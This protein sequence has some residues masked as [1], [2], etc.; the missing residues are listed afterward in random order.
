MIL[1]GALVNLI[2]VV[3]GTF[4]GLVAGVPI[5]A[6]IYTLLKKNL[7]KREGILYSKSLQY[8]P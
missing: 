8:I 6:V 7:H 2:T 4:V 3:A 1:T 5:T